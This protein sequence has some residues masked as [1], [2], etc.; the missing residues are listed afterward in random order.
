MLPFNIKSEENANNQSKQI[1]TFNLSKKTKM[2]YM[3]D[4]KLERIEETLSQGL[5]Q[6][7][8]AS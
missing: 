7:N 2:S 5:N 4:S 3:T 8:R 6:E 1:P